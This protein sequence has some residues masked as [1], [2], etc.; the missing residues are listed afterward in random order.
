MDKV[1][2]AI[3]PTYEI[4]IRS[5]IELCNIESGIARIP[6]KAVQNR[7]LR[8]MV[9]VAPGVRVPRHRLIRN[10]IEIGDF[11]QAQT[12]IRIFDKDFGRDGPVARYRVNLMVAR[13]TRSPGIMLEDRLIILEEARETAAAAVRRY[14]HNPAVFAAYCDVGF[15]MFKL[16][17]RLDVYDEAM[18]R[19][20]DAE[21]RLGD[22][23]ITHT[24]RRFERR[25]GGLVP[26]IATPDEEIIAPELE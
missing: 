13:A 21:A 11:D 24:I 10:L 18:E 23:E 6:D 17:G 9:S 3:V 15:E 8:R 25:V 2:D 26:P 20:R 4:E 12:E 22:P 16:T 1:I 5:I 19:L 7:L 14:P